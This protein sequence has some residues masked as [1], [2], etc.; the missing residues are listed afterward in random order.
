MVENPKNENKDSKYYLF[1][2]CRRRRDADWR[3]MGR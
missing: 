1:V 3:L 2:P